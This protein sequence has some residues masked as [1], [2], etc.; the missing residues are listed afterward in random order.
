MEVSPEAKA[1]DQPVTVAVPASAPS[2]SATTPAATGTDVAAA[3]TSGT[4]GGSVAAYAI[5]GL[6]LLALIAYL[7]VR[8]R[9]RARQ[10]G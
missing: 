4:S 8:S 1:A 3:Q 6:V 9:S 10:D 2:A 7:F 5:A